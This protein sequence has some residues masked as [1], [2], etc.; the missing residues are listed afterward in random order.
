MKESISF[1]AEFN[2]AV[3]FIDCREF[4]ISEINFE[5]RKC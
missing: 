2:C 3:G 5:L 4:F 1:E